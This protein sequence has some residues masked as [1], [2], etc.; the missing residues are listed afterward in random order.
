MLPDHILFD[1][2]YKLYCEKKVCLLVVEFQSIEVLSRLLKLR[3][4]R[5]YLL[6]IFQAL[7]DH[8]ADILKNIVVKFEQHECQNVTKFAF[9]MN[10]ATFYN[11]GGWC[12]EA[13]KVYRIC[14]VLVNSLPGDRA[15]VLKQMID[16][17]QR[18]LHTETNY[19]LFKE[20]ESTIIEADKVVEELEKL[21][22]LPNLAALYSNYSA[23]YFRRS[24]YDKAYKWS[25]RAMK[26]LDDNLPLRVII[27]VLRQASKSSVVYRR[28]PQAGLL[29][30]Q[31]M[32]LATKLYEI[33]EHPQYSD[34]LMDYAFYFLS[35]DSI[36]ESVNYY[37][38]ALKIRKNVFEKN[39][40]QVAVGLENLSYAHYVNEYS[41]GNFYYAREY[42]ER[43]V[44]IMERILPSD[45]LMLASVK[46]VKALILEEIALDMRNTHTQFSQEKILQEAE[47]LHKD[48]LALSH[49]AFG[50][51][52]VQTAK[53]YGN[54]GRLYQSMSNY[55]EAE[56]MH[57]RAIAI[58][59]ELLGPKDYEVGLSIGHLA[60]LYNYHMKKQGD[61]E[62]LYLRSIQIGLELFG[63]SYSGLEYDYRGLIH[64]YTELQDLPNLLHY[65]Y[66]FREWKR[67]RERLVVLPPEIQDPLPVKTIAEQF[68]NLC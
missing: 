44:R 57:L 26:L 55:E 20:A 12:V 4:K 2:Y 41:S 61:A 24:E 60:S 34:T 11:E 33:D 10:L 49:I 23:L 52:N 68:L 5:T 66:I 3:N 56:K 62:K 15:V 36:Q 53:H 27:D 17:F 16:L 19:C 14:D 28:F 65:S 32:G 42:A 46:R 40:L 29:I 63:D 48:A 13:I 7:V 38:K 25:I 67:K 35:Y 45:H 9:G 39:N 8:D 30:N 51:R 54:L 37:E 43:A 22:E 21:N 47:K 50:E 1:F 58:K 31:A 64:A 6:K 18:R 59:E